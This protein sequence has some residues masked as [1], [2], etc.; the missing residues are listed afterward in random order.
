[1]QIRDRDYWLMVWQHFK[2][3]DSKAFEII[4]NEFIDHLYSYGIKM[5]KDHDMVKD[6]IHDLF[7]KLYNC[8]ID[9][10][11]P[12]YIEFYLFKSFRRILVD[13]L[14]QNRNNQFLNQSPEV[15]ISLSFDLENEYILDESERNRLS[16]LK[17]M[18]DSLSPEQKELLFLRFNTGLSYSDIAKILKL[19]PDTVKKQIYRLLDHIRSQYG[20]RFL[21]LFSIVF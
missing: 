18:L 8:D 12:E 17:T 21:E 16:A 19:K 3:G 6:T 5:S 7:I 9:L 4:Y 14:K 11:T 2:A 20:D 13:K 15:A 1:M 10:K